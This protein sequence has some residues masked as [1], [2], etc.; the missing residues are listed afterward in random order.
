MELLFFKCQQAV[1]YASVF[2]PPC[3]HCYLRSFMLVSMPKAFFSYY[4]VPHRIPLNTLFRIGK[5]IQNQQKS[6][7]KA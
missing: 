7:V 5:T 6:E 4:V 2:M 1:K 3:G